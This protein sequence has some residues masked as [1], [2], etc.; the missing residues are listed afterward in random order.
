MPI[1]DIPIL[2]MLRARMAWHQDRQR[3]LAENVSN[4]DTP[5]FRPHDLVPLEFNRPGTAPSASG[6]AAAL[7]GP[8]TL[9][10]TNPMH[11]ATASGPGGEFSQRR[12]GYETRPSGNA[13]N[14]EDQMMKG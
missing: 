14:L 13:V 12:G 2:S 10:R 4:A 1:S 8:V 5:R 9:V 6:P 11:I 7:G 3:V